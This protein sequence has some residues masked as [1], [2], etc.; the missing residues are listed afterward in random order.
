MKLNKFFEISSLWISCIKNWAID[1]SFFLINKVNSNDS[2]NSY[3]IK[4]TNIQSSLLN[5]YSSKKRNLNHKVINIYFKIVYNEL[6]VNHGIITHI[7]S[8]NEKCEKYFDQ[9]WRK[10][11]RI[12]IL[13]YNIIL[14]NFIILISKMN[15]SWIIVRNCWIY[16]KIFR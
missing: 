1:S 11:K 10:F 13:Y 7:L 8:K 16:L 5:I 14:S 3:Y 12:L 4:F 2:I 9:M 6:N 15:M